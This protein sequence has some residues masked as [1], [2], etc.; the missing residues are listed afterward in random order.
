MVKN[1]GFT[2]MELLAVIAILSIIIVISVP[3]IVSIANR[4]KQNMYCNKVKTVLKS[5]Q[6]Y[7]EDNISTFDGDGVKCSV[8]SKQIEKCQITT[9]RDLAKKGYLNLEAV[10]NATAKNEFLDPRTYTSMLND[11]VMIFIVNKRV[12]ASFVYNNKRDGEKCTNSI[13]IGNQSYK[14]FYY[15]NGGVIT[16]N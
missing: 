5:A 16:A 11:R 6:L 15:E 8:S 9:I 13:K 1:K 10:N 3:A 4:N 12:S 14:E 7:G 2:M